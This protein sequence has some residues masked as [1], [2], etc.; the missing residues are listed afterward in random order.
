MFTNSQAQAVV[1]TFNQ[2]NWDVTTFTGSYNDNKSK[3]D[4][5]ANGGVMPWW[6]SDFEVAEA[7]AAAVGSN[8]GLQSISPLPTPFPLL[9]AGPLFGRDFEAGR[10]VGWFIY[11]YAY[12][13]GVPPGDFVDFNRVVTFLPT[14]YPPFGIPPGVLNDAGGGTTRPNTSYTWAQATLVPASD[15]PGPLPALGLAAAFGF[16]RQ[17]RKRIKA[18]SNSSIAGA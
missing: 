14:G 17:L 12:L 4:T 15:V 5:P 6:G 16:S 1:V 18:S 11:A 9:S 10:A 8:L 7:F 2:Q 13:L 3:F